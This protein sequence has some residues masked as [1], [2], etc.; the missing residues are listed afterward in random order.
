MAKAGA[1]YEQDFF[2]WTKEQAAA[3]RAGTESSNPPSSS[4]ESSANS[5]QV[6]RLVRWPRPERLKP[7]SCLADADII[8]T[9]EVPSLSPGIGGKR[10]S[11]ASF[12]ASAPLR[13]SAIAEFGERRTRPAR[14]ATYSSAF[15]QISRSRTT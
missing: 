4:G 8:A 1:L 6:Q 3:L 9:S 5:A 2:L 10:G 13:T 11:F 7:Y 14:L 12:P 15:A